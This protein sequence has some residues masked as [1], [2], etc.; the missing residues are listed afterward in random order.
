MKKTYTI[1]IM[2]ILLLVLVGCTSGNL[3]ESKPTVIPV[4]PNQDIQDD[5]QV[6]A[7]QKEESANESV[8][9]QEENAI[10]LSELSMHNSKNDCW[11]GL[12]GNVYDIT[13]L[14]PGH[15]GGEAAIIRYCGTASEFEKALRSKHGTGK[16][17]R[18]DS[19][20]VF[21]GILHGHDAVFVLWALCGSVPRGCLRHDP[22]I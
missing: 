20:A 13:S 5:T 12:E 3:P 8:S 22:G 9:D 19:K 18:I 17:A 6:T 2:S 21:K 16:D 14:I 4:E 15:P 1:L 7:E 10:S 11:I